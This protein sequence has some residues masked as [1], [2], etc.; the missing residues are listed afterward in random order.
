VLDAQAIHLFSE[1]GRLAY[2]DRNRYVADTDFVP[3]PGKGIA[4]MLD[5]PTWRSAPR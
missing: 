2:A 4:S 5:K 3:L 1:A